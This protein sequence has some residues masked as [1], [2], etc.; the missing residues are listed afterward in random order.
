MFSFGEF[1]LSS[2]SFPF[3]HQTEKLQ[4][5]LAECVSKL[6]VSKGLLI[7]EWSNQDKLTIDSDTKGSFSIE[8]YS[9]GIA[10]WAVSRSTVDDIVAGIAG[11]FDLNV[12]E[13]RLT[14]EGI[15]F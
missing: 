11:G 2:Q 15:P 14:K 13:K 7:F 8:I 4:I 6:A 5:R 3:T 1:S 9:G 10:G 12:I